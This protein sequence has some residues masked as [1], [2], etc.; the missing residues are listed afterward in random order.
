MPDVRV[1]L[2]T[3]LDEAMRRIGARSE[4]EAIAAGVFGDSVVIVHGDHGGRL[5]LRLPTVKEQNQLTP[6]DYGDGLSTLFAAKL[7]GKPGGYDPS[8]H[9]I[10]ELFVQTLSYAFGKTPPLSVPRG[11]PFAYLYN[12]S[13]KELLLVDMPWR[14]MNLPDIPTAAQ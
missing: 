6:A 2:S 8:L 10:N 9:A 7:P 13:R 14:P 1:K 3:G 12:G 11:E 5:G 4:L